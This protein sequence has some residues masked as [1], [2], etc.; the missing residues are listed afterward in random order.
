MKDKPEVEAVLRQL[1]EVL[2]REYHPEKVILFGSYA[3]GEPHA[4]SD[5]DLLIIKNTDLPFYKRGGQVRK[6]IRR[7]RGSLPMDIIV[8]T[9]PE[10]SAQLE[11]GNVFLEQVL[12]EGEVLFEQARVAAS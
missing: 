6:L 9:I 11:R 7:V 5:V 1:L 2:I 4:D 3:S 12:R 8:L 10:L